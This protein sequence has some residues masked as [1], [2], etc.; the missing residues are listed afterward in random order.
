[1]AGV[2]IRDVA[3]K[4]RVSVGTVSRVLNNSASVKPTNREKVLAA[5]NELNYIPNPIARRL[6]LK[7]TLTIAVIVPFF[8]RPAMVERLRGVEHIIAQSKYDLILFNVETV[9]RL[10]EC[11]QE[12]PRRERVDGMLIISLSPRENDVDYLLTT[13]VPIVLIDAYHSRLSRLVTDDRTG[14]YLAAKHLIELGHRKIGFIS[15]YLDNTFNFVANRERYLGYRRALTEA[16]LPFKPEYH[17]ESD[18]GHLYTKQNAKELFALPDPPTAI[19]AAS[20]TKAIGVLE[21]AHEVGLR[22]PEDLSLVGYDDIEVAKYL[23]L[24]TVH[25]SFFESGTKGVEIL[26]DLIDEPKESPK[27]IMMSVELIV[28]KTTAPPSR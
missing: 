14:G 12:V 15:N 21:A 25:Q 18:F 2:T 27:E 23:H 19:I 28:R 24:T 26:L 6:S 9:E 11:L 10:N 20:D 17:R 3:K 13:G 1:M 7:K 4:A 8:T 22:I 5:I 16:N